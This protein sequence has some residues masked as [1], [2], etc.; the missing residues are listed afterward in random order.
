MI[1]IFYDFLKRQ[2]IIKMTKTDIERLGLSV[3]TLSKYENLY[4]YANSIKL[5]I[6]KR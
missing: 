5:R 2:S 6:K 3:I 4:G 1:K